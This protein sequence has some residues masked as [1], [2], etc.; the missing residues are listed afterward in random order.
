VPNLEEDDFVLW[1]KYKGFVRDNKDPEN[2]GRVRVF[3]PQVMGAEDGEDQWLGWAE[4]CFPWMGGLST[5]DFGPPFTREEQRSSYGMEWYGVWIE[6]ER[7]HPDFP[8]WVGTFTIART[9]DTKSALKMG[10]S[11]GTGQVG[12]GILPL[13]NSPLNP[14][15]FEVSREVRM[16]APKGVDLIIG[17][18]GGGSLIIGASGVHVVGPQVTVNGKVH[19][20]SG[21]KRGG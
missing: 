2:R 16:R 19:L 7:G 21:T 4:P 14:P 15:K 5:G 3:C 9:K 11:G 13:L 1:G 17:S 18:E 10:V 8:I 6:F 12:G 20:A